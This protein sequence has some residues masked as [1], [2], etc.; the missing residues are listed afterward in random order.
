M[1]RHAAADS[2][3]RLEM[4]CD[5]GRYAEAVR[6]ATRYLA[7]HPH[8]V[9]ALCLLSLA[10]LETDEPAEALR[11]AGAA[12][13]AAPQEEWPH[14]LASCAL[15]RLGRLPEAVAAAAAAIDADPFGALPR[16]Q[17]AEAARAH[18]VDLRAARRAAEEAV[19]LDPELVDA[20]LALGRVA[21]AQRRTRDAEAAFR[22]ALRLDPECGLAHRQ[23]ARLRMNG[24]ADGRVAP[25][26]AA[27]GAAAAGFGTSLRTDPTAA[28]GRAGLE[29]VAVGV[30]MRTSGI[31][32]F[33]A[34]V[35]LTFAVEPASPR[36][37]SGATTALLLFGLGFVVRFLRRLSPA[38]RRQLV[39]GRLLPWPRLQ[40]AAFTLA[41]VLLG[42]GAAV[43]PVGVIA[44]TGALTVTLVAYG[45]TLP[46]ARRA[47]GA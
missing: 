23:L 15:Q 47:R 1:S 39:R 45:A 33:A 29:L 35:G 4:L 40:V 28:Q 10:L 9:P 11:V 26:G 36:A 44:F 32:C 38:V 25:S 14:R 8:D 37:A 5:L 20:H 22:A 34:L 27:L 41:A 7:S 12:A 43:P 6:E 24:W 21:A 46:R 30:A 16:V 2:P 17:F 18:G 19:A 13:G 31:L 3:A 42:L